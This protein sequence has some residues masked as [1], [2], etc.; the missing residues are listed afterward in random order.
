MSFSESMREL[1][2]CEIDEVSGCGYLAGATLGAGTLAVIATTAGALVAA[3]FALPFVTVG[4]AM[5]LA[6]AGLSYLDT[7]YGG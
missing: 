4:A 5:G 3:P 6:A 1:E 7:Q 2:Q